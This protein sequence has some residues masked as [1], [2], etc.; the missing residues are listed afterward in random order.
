MS[1]EQVLNI[2][3]KIQ[4]NIDKLAYVFFRKMRQPSDFTISDLQQEG[5]NAAI[6]QIMLGRPDPEKGI[7]QTYLIRCVITRFISLMRKSYKVNPVT[8]VSSRIERQKRHAFLSSST[9]SDLI[10][11]LL[12]SL[13]PREKEYISLLLS[14][15]EDIR[16]RMA[17]DRRTTRKLVRE[18]LNM[19]GAEERSIR[20]NIKML[21]RERE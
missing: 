14:P 15:P 6:Q 16:D 13:K 3:K 20:T 4:P 9:D 11:D 8:N 1:E 12:D 21:L 7:I 19:S 2:I 17:K 10:I 5:R 18:V